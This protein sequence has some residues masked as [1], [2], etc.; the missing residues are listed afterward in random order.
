MT[1]SKVIEISRSLYVLVP[2]D[3]ARRLNLKPGQ[4]VDLEIKPA[5]ATVGDLIR[6]A[7]GKFKDE[8]PPTRIPKKELWRI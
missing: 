2:A 8:F 1:E 5:G 4:R 7:W 6:D 3:E